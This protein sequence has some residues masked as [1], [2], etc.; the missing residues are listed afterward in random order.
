MNGIKLF[1]R[2]D[3]TRW[4]DPNPYPNG[5]DIDG[6]DDN[7][8][9]Y[10]DGKEAVYTADPEPSTYVQ[11]PYTQDQIFNNA[12]S[13]YNYDLSNRA[14][15]LVRFKT[16]LAKAQAEVVKWERIIKE[17][18]AETSNLN[19]WIADLKKKYGKL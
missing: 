19:K 15:E 8:N 1:A 16:Y 18:E 2:I 4:N 7:G 9:F 14:A 10:E 6:R 13:C 5:I 11:K 3:M 12:L 17:N